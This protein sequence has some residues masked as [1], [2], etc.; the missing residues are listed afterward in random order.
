[1]LKMKS[2]DLSSILKTYDKKGKPHHEGEKT[3]V[4]VRDVF[5]MQGH[6]TVSIDKFVFEKMHFENIKTDLTLVPYRIDVNSL[7]ADAMGGQIT[8]SGYIAFTPG[9]HMILNLGLNIDKV[10]LPVLFKEYDNFG[11][12]TLTDANLKGRF[13]ATLAIRTVWNNYKEIDFDKLSGNLTCS[14][15]HG[16]LNNF[17]P[18]KSASA[19][20]KVD[21]LNHIVFSDLTNT[22]SIKDRVITIPRMEIQ[23]SAVNLIMSG[24]HT[25]DNNID[26]HIKVNL[27]KLLAAKF[28]Q[29]DRDVQYIEEDPYDGVNLYL[30]LTGDISNPKI[31]YD[32]ESVKKKI[33]QDLADQ[34]QELKDLFKKDKTKKPAKEEETKREEKYYD[35]RKKPEYIEFEEDKKE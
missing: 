7:S 34:K 15:L 24:T 10:D 18:I 31:K 3:K 32:R 27:H 35:T 4:D 30:T 8:N 29:R 6:L 20:I 5:N 22:L 33:K 28:G 1:S 9:K 2:F 19:F 17:D 16:E 26:Y 21:E 11:Q 25:L 12:K 23:S 13:S 14:V